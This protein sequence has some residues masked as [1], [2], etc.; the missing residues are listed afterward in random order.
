MQTKSVI[1]L[2]VIMMM[3]T[4]GNNI[5][6]GQFGLGTPGVTNGNPITTAGDPNAPEVPFD[7]GMSLMFAAAG[8]GYAKKKFFKIKH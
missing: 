4:V 3:L 7:G 8:V 5:A 2:V 1:K 6:H